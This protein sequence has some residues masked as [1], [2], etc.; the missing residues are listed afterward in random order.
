MTSRRRW[1]RNALVG[2]L[3]LVAGWG[4]AGWL[5]VGAPDAVAA[6][7]TLRTLAAARGLRIGSAVNAV[8][9]RQE[10]GYRDKLRY[11]FNGVT[12]ENAMKWSQV[13]PVPG[14]YAWDDADAIVD[15][16]EQSG[17]MV[18]GHPLVWHSA[19]PEWLTSGSFTD[20]QLRA[21]LKQHIEDMTTR[22]AGRV[23][24]WDVVNEAFNEDGTLRPSIWLDR[25]GSGYIADAFRWA[26][27]A[28]P[29]AKLY[30]NDFNA[31]WTNPKSD[32]LYALV[33]DLR[34]QGVPVDGVGFQT[35]VTTNSALS[36]LKATLARFAGLGIDVAV[37]ELD[38]RMPLP[39][40]D[41]K[42]TTQATVYRRA[43]DACLAVARCVSLT[44]W[45]FTDAHSWVPGAVPG[46]GAADLLDESLQPKP[47]YTSVHDGLAARD[48]T[49][50]AVAVQSGRCLDVPNSTAT[51]GVQLQQY[52]CNSTG[53]QRFVYNRVGTK[54]YTITNAQNALCVTVANGSTG[55]G[56][57]VLQS[58]CAGL[59]QQKFELYKVV[60][61]DQDYKL[62]ATHSGKCLRVQD[63]STADFA[64]IEQWP[65]QTD[66][67]AP[68][69]QVWRLTA[70]PGHP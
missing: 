53:A 25:L 70:A 12:P 30:I 18:R 63:D 23:G 49:G 41:T 14:Q 43:I 5:V 62:A 65:C 24:A 36:Q 40:D 35:H 50:T 38:V 47:A 17:Q 37:T 52:G 55:N 28:D 19:L 32:A 22:Y 29:A 10:K 7:S 2:A 48:F 33:R 3:V 67:A 34:A 51:G 59:A 69:K 4:T 1:A 11:E 60:G 44:V 31:E 6:E 56:A 16:A 58:P 61:S 26:R 8:P 20:E 39:A 64:R 27:A 46:W 66:P 68:S 15:F 9:L 45:G 54:T 13:E 21:I 42:L 57:A